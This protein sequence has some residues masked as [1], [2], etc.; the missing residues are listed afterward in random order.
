MVLE[1]DQLK[2]QEFLSKEMEEDISILTRLSAGMFSE[3]YLFVAKKQE[4]VVRINR[5]EQDF[6]KDIYAYQ[7]FGDLLPIPKIVKEGRYDNEYY[8]SI[9][10]K[11]Q[12]VTHD[13]LDIKS[14]KDILPELIK[15]I[16]AMR[17]INV[18]NQK[19]F[20]LMDKNGVGRN[21]SWRLALTAFYN[22]KFPEIDVQQ[23][24][25]KSILDRAFFDAC[26]NQLFNLFAYIPEE[27][28]LV[29]GDFGFDNLVVDEGKITGILDW[30]ESKYGDFL[31]DIAWLDFWSS[32]E[33]EYAKEFKSYY[34][35]NKIDIQHFDR[36]I[37]CYRLYIGLNGLIL[38]AYLDNKQDYEK[39]KERVQR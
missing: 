16:E 7:H 4:Y 2:L 27:K 14:A 3:A 8:Y 34:A 37:R 10:S 13:K 38:A 35:E 24:F 22:H 9:A 19:G 33:I 15:T 12:G 5:H 17:L 36:R 39:I 30:A 1:R 20:G 25:D 29:H 21:D 6:Q 28:H 32:N 31:Y 18:K 23:L 11:C 26:F